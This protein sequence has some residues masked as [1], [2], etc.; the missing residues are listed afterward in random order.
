MTTNYPTAE[1][2]Q[3]RLIPEN[4][5]RVPRT[6]FSSYRHTFMTLKGLL[7]LVNLVNAESKVKPRAESYHPL[8]VKFYCGSSNALSA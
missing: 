5:P 7:M 1:E 2:G 6:L 8:K 4:V 3:T